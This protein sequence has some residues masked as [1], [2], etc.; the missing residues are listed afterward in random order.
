MY[1]I[2]D[3]EGL[4]MFPLLDFWNFQNLHKFPTL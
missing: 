3:L 4:G 2:Y 1:I